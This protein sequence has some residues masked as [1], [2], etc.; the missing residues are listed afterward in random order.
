[1]P[2]HRCELDHLDKWELG[3]R[4]D[5]ETSDL[6]CEIHHIAR[7]CGLFHAVKVKGSRPMV[8]LP[9]EPDPEQRLQFNTYFFSPSEALRLAEWARQATVLWRAGRLDASIADP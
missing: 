7:H 3:G 8:L 9:R 1:M 2:A 6:Y 4:T 5:I